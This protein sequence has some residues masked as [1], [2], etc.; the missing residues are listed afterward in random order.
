MKGKNL[1]DS[2]EGVIEEATIEKAMNIIKERQQEIRRIQRI[3]NKAQKDF[4]ELLEM[5][6]EDIVEEY[7]DDFEY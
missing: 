2:V 5:D 3:L 6:I 7:S 4:D 1:F